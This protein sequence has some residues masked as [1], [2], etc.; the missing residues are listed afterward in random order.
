MRSDDH[1]WIIFEDI[2]RADIWLAK[3]DAGSMR[4]TPDGDNYE[5]QQS[6]YYDITKL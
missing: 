5:V 1:L 6:Q 4:W 3:G 2:D